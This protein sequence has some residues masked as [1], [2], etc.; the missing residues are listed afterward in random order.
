VKLGLEVLGASRSGSGSGLLGVRAC[1]R[2]WPMDSKEPG[3]ETVPRKKGSL[4]GVGLPIGIGV[5][6]G[7]GSAIHKVGA[8]VA[9]GVA[10]GVI[11]G[12]LLD[13]IRQKS[14]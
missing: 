8:G 4:I 10:F 9:I 5:G 13:K 7:I 14:D 1:G 3:G 6:A 11:L 12:A 2:L